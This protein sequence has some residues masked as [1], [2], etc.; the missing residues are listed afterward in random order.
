[1]VLLEL[2]EDRSV[3]AGLL[4]RRLQKA[5]FW[6]LRGLLPAVA[7]RLGGEVVLVGDILVVGALRRYKA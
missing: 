2:G 5:G 6:L 4:A 1:M 7:T 3:A